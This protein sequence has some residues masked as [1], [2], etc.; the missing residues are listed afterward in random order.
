MSES[1]QRWLWRVALVTGLALVAASV[2]V[3]QWAPVRAGFAGSY[4]SSRAA[5][6]LP[7]R[8]VSTMDS[9]HISWRDAGRVRYDSNPPTSGP[10]FA[11][12]ITTGIYPDPV[13][14]GLLVHALEHGH[15]EILYAPD[16]PRPTVRDLESIARGHA[17][18]VVLA[19]YPHLPRGIAVTAWGRIETLDTL[20][21]GRIDEFVRALAGRYDHG[22]TRPD[23]C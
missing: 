7:G 10:H 14:D 18:E 2:L 23:P 3:G 6:C 12:T 16:T 19:P 13:P 9:P 4:A 22:W 20:D 11:F 1:I 17:D 8:A 15:V 21:A 5:P